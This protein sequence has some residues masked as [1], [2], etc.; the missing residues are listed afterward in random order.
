MKKILFIPALCILCASCNSDSGNVL[1]YSSGNNKEQSQPADWEITA[2]V[3]KTLLMDSSLS[4]HARLISVT[5]NDGVVV[6]TGTVSS[7]DE[8]RK[9]VK[10]VKSVTGVKSVD[11]QLTISNS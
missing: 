11:N 1:G 6:L 5:T 3:K 7:K 8:R 2:N 4:A 10:M 9:V